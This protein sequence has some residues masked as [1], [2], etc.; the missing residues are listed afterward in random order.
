MRPIFIIFFFSASA[1]AAPLCESVFVDENSV[2]LQITELAGLLIA[3]R[4]NPKDVALGTDFRKK[5]LEVETGAGRP[6]KDE[7]LR[8]EKAADQGGSLKSRSR[9]TDAESLM[10][11]ARDESFTFP[12]GPSHAIYLDE[13][14]FL[15]PQDNEILVFDPKTNLARHLSVPGCAAASPLGLSPDHLSVFV[16]SHNVQRVDLK[17]GK[18]RAADS[19][20]GGEPFHQYLSV[21]KAGRFVAATSYGDRVTIIDA[22]SLLPIATLRESRLAGRPLF[23]GLRK[24]SPSDR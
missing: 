18:V 13:T 20:I 11:W 17:T 6:I 10:K 21:S 4:A 5:Y 1:L 22:T 15:V 14:T 12:L 16:G 7:V 8:L 24:L 3:V 2:G 9:Q 19:F 23:F